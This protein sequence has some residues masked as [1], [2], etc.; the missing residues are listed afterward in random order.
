MAVVIQ[1]GLV[2]AVVLW[3]MWIAHLLLFRGNGLADWIGLV[4][5]AQNIVGSLFNS[6]LFDFVQGWVYV[7]GVGVAGGIVNCQISKSVARSTISR[8]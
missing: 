5:V 3:A 1:L 2:G 8:S 4:I 6:H 7:I